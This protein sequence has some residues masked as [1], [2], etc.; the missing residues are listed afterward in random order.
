MLRAATDDD[1]PR[2]RAWRNHPDVRAVSLTR[3]EIGEQEHA[4]WW[5][6]TRDDDSRRV[7]VY[8]R[9]GVPCGVATLTGLGAEDGSATW[10][11]YLDLDGLEARGETLPA[12][13]QIGRELVRYAFDDLH[14]QVLRGEV[15][16]RNESVRRMNRLWGFTEAGPRV[17]HLDGEDVEV[18]DLELR[19]DA[20]R[21]SSGG[22]RPR[23]IAP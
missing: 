7:L 23:T 1:V 10:G 9:S 14:L 5:A 17:E 11:F 18:F 16:G 2:M 22:G 3:H 8:E 6:R 4:Q 13:M 12:W 19:A 20:R 15:L 21:A